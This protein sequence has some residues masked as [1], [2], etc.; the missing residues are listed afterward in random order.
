M[1]EKQEFKLE[2]KKSE[3]ITNQYV[4]TSNS[5]NQIQEKQ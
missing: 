2:Q 4:K 1:R 3:F 5:V